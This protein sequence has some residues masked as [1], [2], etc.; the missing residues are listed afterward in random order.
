MICFLMFFTNVFSKTKFLV[1]YGKFDVTKVIGYDL[2]VVES[3]HFNYAEIS[4]L[5]RNNKKVLAYIS[6]GEINENARDFKL[7]KSTVTD[8][9]MDWNSYYLDIASEKV[10]TI[11]E[12]RIRNIYFMGYDGLFLD[13]IDNYSTYGVQFHLQSNLVAFVKKMRQDF[14]TKVLIQNSGL[15]LVRHLDSSVDYILVE[16]VFTDYNFAEKK[17]LMRTPESMNQRLQAIKQSVKDYHKK[18]LLLEYVEEGGA[19][20]NL[21][22]KLNKERIP[23]QIAEISLQKIH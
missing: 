15:E 7:L 16:S 12:S 18:V 9:N 10:K 17:Y 13:N 20:K 4:F 3:A 5:K 23:Y 8:K 6:L 11:L 22:K 2:L 21:R 19:I 1:C 14:P